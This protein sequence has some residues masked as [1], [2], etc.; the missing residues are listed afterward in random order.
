MTTQTIGSGAQIP[1]YTCQVPKE[2]PK[3]EQASV[4]TPPE[5]TVEYQE[6]KNDITIKQ[7][8]KCVA[9]GLIGMGIE[10]VGN[11]AS[12]IGSILKPTSNNAV[13]QAGKTIWK[14]DMIGTNLK[15]AATILLPVATL[16]AP[17][18]TAIGS[19]G[20]GLF[21]GGYEG[22]KEDHGLND[23]VKE[24]I[25]DVKKFHKY[26]SDDMVDMLQEVQEPHLEPGQEPIDIKVLEAGK[27]LVGAAA[28]GVVDGVGM[29][30]V[31]WAKLPKATFRA[32]QAVLN[33][34]SG[35]V[36]KTTAAILL[37]IPVA[38]A[39]PLAPVAAGVYGVYKGF[40]DGYNKGILE[41]VGNRFEEVGKFHK[42]TSE[43][44]A[45]EWK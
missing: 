28:G 41:S 16:A 4:Q 1:Q 2:E 44:L 21:R 38:L 34:D 43:L 45:K 5:D 37:P 33:M 22:A 32:Y 12:C 17:I 10:T 26:S 3:E 35:P 31:T 30:A 13:W 27:G 18:L 15:I 40:A 29:T 25:K 14:T 36:L 8:V 11:T 42:D 24:T 9:G 7:A 39:V 23:A 19:A 20:Y 6:P